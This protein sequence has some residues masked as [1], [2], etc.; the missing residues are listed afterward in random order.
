MIFSIREF[1]ILII[2]YV[3]FNLHADH[4]LTSARDLTGSYGI[5]ISFTSSSVISIFMT[6]EKYGTTS[7]FFSS[8]ISFTSSFSLLRVFDLD[9][10]ITSSL[11]RLLDLDDEIT[12]TLP[13]LLD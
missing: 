8:S 2:F 6:Y 3:S 4:T 7:S 11:P 5:G 10:E 9:D 13:R 12:S 1:S